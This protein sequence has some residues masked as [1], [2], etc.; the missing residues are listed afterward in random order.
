MNFSNELYI[1]SITWKE[2][3]G[4]LI[5]YCGDTHGGIYELDITEYI[6]IY[7]FTN[8]HAHRVVLSKFIKRYS[9]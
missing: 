8:I 3:N 2:D 9:V 7:I 4:R 6:H 1:S 5:V